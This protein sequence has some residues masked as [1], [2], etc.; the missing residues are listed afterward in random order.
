MKNSKKTFF[1]IL[2]LL[3]CTA[4]LAADEFDISASNINILQNNEKI[5]AEGSVVVKGQDGIIIEAESATY[6]KKTNFLDAEK[7]VKITDTKTNNK[8]TSDRVQYFKNSEKIIAEGNVIFKGQGGIIIEAESATYDKNEQVIKSDNL[9]TIKDNSGNSIILDM[10]NYSVKNKNLRSEGNIEITD[11][12]ENKYFFDDI[13][14]DVENKRMAGSNLKIKFNKNTFG[15]IENDPRLVANSAVITE[16]KSYIEKGVFT[17][18]KK[19][20]NKC[21]PWKMAAKK[22]IHDK[23]K[24]TINYENAKLYFYDLPIFYFPRFFHPDPTVE[25]QSG[26]L[27]P[28]LTNSTT[29]G[30]GFILPYYFALADHK[31]LTL[32]PKMYVDENPVIQTEYRHVTKNSY[33]ILDT[34]YNQGYKKASGNK[35]GSSRAHLF[36]Q[37]NINLDLETFDESNLMIN[38]QK[39]TNDTYLRAHNIDSKIMDS[40][41][42][43]NS[44]IDLNFEKK[45]S[46]L[47]INMDVYED[48]NKTSDKYEYVI[49]NFDYKNN[50]FFSE[51]LGELNFQSRGSHKIY[52]TNK[53]E[54]KMVNDFFWNSN[55]FISDSGFITSFNGNLKNSNYRAEKTSDFKSEENNYEFAGVISLTNSFPLKKQSK[56]Y[57]KTLTPKLMLRTAPGHM[58]DMS[59]EKLKFGTSNLFT[60]NKLSQI[61][62]IEKGTSLTLGTD[63]SYKDKKKDFEKIN[64]SLGQVFNFEDNLKMSSSSS[65]G[66]KTSELVGNFDYNI[67]ESSK[68]NYKFSLDDNFND[69]N[70][71]EITGVFKINNLV[72]NFE[73]LEENNHIGDSHYID[74]GLSLELNKSNSLNFKTRKNFVTN[75]TEFYNWSFQYE[76]DCLRAA[77]EYNRNFYSDRDLQPADDLL[78]T[79]TIIPFGKIISP[80]LKGN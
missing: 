55:K 77:L 72:T 18:C 11:K 21:P 64:L 67:N 23:G 80:P 65:L 7:S 79:L 25:R 68:L 37:S 27:A 51:Q 59:G 34:S 50:L 4:G 71:N 17:T 41:S 5:I 3:F 12:L 43:L 58:R 62:V 78:F 44:S 56:N 2:I 61:D 66:Q 39:V 10:F 1:S 15:N 53:T 47:E 36:A 63:Y 45:D 13:F 49:P 29:L 22:I 33:S 32:T 16:N 38:L 6:D 42:L 40:K 60:L 9:A 20:G 52:E 46:S 24:Q 30:A 70:Y 14:I 73:Y 57:E 8:I 69:L 54:A 48:L 35:S 28:R 19:R 76:N 26:F 74:A 31:D 75:A